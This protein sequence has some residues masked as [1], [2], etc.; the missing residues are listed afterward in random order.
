MNDIYLRDELMQVYKD[1]INRGV[2]NNATV[3]STK[4]N[5]MCGDAVKLDLLVSEDGIVVD[6]K[7][8]GDACAVSIISSSLLTEQ[9]IGNTVNEAKKISK[10]DILNMFSDDLTTSRIKCATLV[11]EALQEALKSYGQ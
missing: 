1:P 10:K 9:I 4:Y 6:A 3:S 2:I 8:S 7:F 5:P 11:L